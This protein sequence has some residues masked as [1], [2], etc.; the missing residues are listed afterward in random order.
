MGIAG[1]MYRI[2]KA[3]IHGIMDQVEDKKLLLRQHLR[4]M[5][6][7]LDKKAAGIRRMQTEMKHAEAE[8]ERIV[9]AI[10]KTETDLEMALEKGR[11][12]I[13][14]FLIRKEKALKNKENALVTRMRETGEN[15][16]E[17]KD[18][19]E[20]HKQTF[21]TIR[22]QAE[23]YFSKIPEKD[24]D[25][26]IHSHSGLTDF[27]E[28]SDEEVELELLRRKEAMGKKEEKS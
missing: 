18:A 21:E 6:D 26:F 7:E 23:T 1:R 5:E 25:P 15:L 17:M 3:D 22:I 19:Y 4:D 9:R 10:Q 28:P 27:S 13:A 16:G 20:K 8:K 12:E 11:D 2:W 24:A 14:K